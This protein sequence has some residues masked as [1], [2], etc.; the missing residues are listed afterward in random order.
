MSHTTIYLLTDAK[1]LDE[2]EHEVSAFLE[3]ESFYDYFDVMKDKSGSL[4]ERRAELMAFIKDWD[5]IRAANE[6]ME[7]AEKYKAQGN[8]VRYGNYLCNAGRL[9]SQYLYTDTYAYTIDT[10]D[11]SIPKDD[12]GWWLIAVDFHY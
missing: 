8:M 7:Q 12:K 1:G 9:Y 2:A 3:G 4:E 6:I 5:W 10:G 11:Y